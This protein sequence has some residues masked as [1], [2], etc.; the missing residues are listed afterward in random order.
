[1]PAAPRG[2]EETATGK[3]RNTPPPGSSTKSVSNDVWLLAL[4][5]LLFIV[6]PRFSAGD[7]G[8]V[9]SVRS[10]QV[11]EGD[12]RFLAREV[13][14][15]VEMFSALCCDQTGPKRFGSLSYRVIPPQNY[16]HLPKA[17]IFALGLTVLLAAGAPPLPPNGDQWH[18]L[19]E[20]HLPQVPQELSPPF[21][22]LL[23]V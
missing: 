8:H 12:S 3:R 9:T 14:H 19:R 10:P 17:D 18:R 23:Q 13:L 15:E 6:Q 20:G 11:E 22:G 7:L 5:L 4:L 1:M 2:L 16:S 21:R